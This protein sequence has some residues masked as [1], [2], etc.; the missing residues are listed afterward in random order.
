[1]ARVPGAADTTLA[2]VSVIAGAPVLGPSGDR[3]GMVAEVMLETGAGQIA[4]VALSV[5][6]VLG[7]GER[8][9]A[10]PWSAFVIDPVGGVLRLRFGL[11]ALGDDPGFDKDAWP[12]AADPR[13][14]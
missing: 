13:L 4:Y 11:T 6:G 14:G 8:L 9:F 2:P 10:V 5:G 3:V 12:V 7:F 1:M